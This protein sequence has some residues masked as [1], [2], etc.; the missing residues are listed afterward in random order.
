MKARFFRVV[1]IGANRLLKSA[2]NMFAA[3][4]NLWWKK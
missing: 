3:I 1:A 2:E 4:S